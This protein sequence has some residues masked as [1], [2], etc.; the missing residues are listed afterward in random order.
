[1]LK[2]VKRLTQLRGEGYLDA[3]YRE[4]S[5]G[6]N[7]RDEDREWGS[8]MGRGPGAFSYGGRFVLGYLCRDSPSSQLRNCWSADGARSAYLARTCL[9]SQSAPG[10]VI[11]CRGV[12]KDGGVKMSFCTIYLL[13]IIDLLHNTKGATFWIHSIAS[14]IVS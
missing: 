10:C 13:Q 4:M 9:K 3:E 8:W 5:E 7:H 12:K 1:M 14:Y 11:V 2:N 6:Q